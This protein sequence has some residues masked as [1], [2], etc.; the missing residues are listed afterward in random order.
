MDK[1]TKFKAWVHKELSMRKEEYCSKEELIIR[2]GTWNVNGKKP[3]KEKDIGPWVGDGDAD[4]YAFGF[5]EIVDLSAGNMLLDHNASAPWE[6]RIQQLL[7]KQHN[8]QKIATV[9]LV[10]L[11]LTIFVKKNLMQHITDVQTDTIGVGILGVGGNKGA[12]VVRFE[13]WNSSLCFINTHLAAH[14]NHVKQRN[15]DYREITKRLR[16]ANA[17]GQKTIQCWDHD[18]LFWLGDLNYRLNFASVVHVDERIRL[19]DWAHLLKHDQLCTERNAKRAFFG[20]QEGEV[21]FP[22]TY[23]YQSGTNDYERRPEKKIRMP[24]WTD[25]IQWVGNNIQQLSYDRAEMIISDHKPV[26]S[27]F[28]YFALREHMEKKL[29]LYETLTDIAEMNP[30]PLVDVSQ[31]EIQFGHVQFGTEYKATLSIRNIGQAVAQV[32][33]SGSAVREEEEWED[34]DIRNGLI[35]FQRPPG[36]K[37]WLHISPAGGRIAPHQT[38]KVELRLAVTRAEAHALNLGWEQLHETVH[39]HVKQGLSSL[40]TVSGSFERS[41]LGCDLSVLTRINGPLDASDVDLKQPSHSAVPPA[42]V[43]L[44][45]A[46]VQLN[47]LTTRNDVLT[48]HVATFSSAHPFRADSP[49]LEQE[50][51]SL[52][53][54]LAQHTPLPKQRTLNGITLALLQTLD[55]LP[56]PLLSSSITVPY[57]KSM[58]LSDWCKKV[59]L[60]LPPNEYALLVYLVSFLRA[61]LQ[62]EATHKMTAGVLAYPFA[63]AFTHLL[64]EGTFNEFQPLSPFIITMQLLTASFKNDK[65]LEDEAGLELPPQL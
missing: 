46:F 28:R 51:W 44:V 10:G 12:T 2:I 56:V 49:A 43:R 61:F 29:Q 33:L 11:S 14:Q 62:H 7:G 52:H 50:V 45:D 18:A 37:S 35:N 13:I 4:I 20:F 27:S 48:Q 65:R 39:V 38:L 32:R 5:Q 40:V 16:F 23:K 26:F 60:E 36:L 19:K 3:N 42:L 41:L 24:A 54:A 15:R 57:Y 30:T 63:R 1:N 17:E 9:H 25:R 58:Q 59:L 34:T 55:A 21:T 47:G 53:R 64:P 8:H 22:P 6:A 31:A